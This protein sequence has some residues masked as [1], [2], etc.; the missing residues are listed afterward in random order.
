MYTLVVLIII[1]FPW[2]LVATVL[3][4]WLIRRNRRERAP[5][6]AR[7]TIRRTA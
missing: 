7:A 5:R 3:I 2:S 1:L 6:R 4:G